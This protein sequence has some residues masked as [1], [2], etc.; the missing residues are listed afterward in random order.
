MRPILLFL[1]LVLIAT[2]IFGG[3]RNM[4]GGLGYRPFVTAMLAV[5]VVGF[6]LVVWNIWRISLRPS[7]QIGRLV[8][9]KKYDEAIALGLATPVEDLD[10]FGKINMVAAYHFSGK[11]DEARTLLATIEDSDH[12]QIQ[13]V[14]ENWREKLQKA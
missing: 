3:M 4:A 2:A 13:T 10:I 1:I 7:Y 5:F 6:L 11:D 12:P 14:I 9:A 8:G